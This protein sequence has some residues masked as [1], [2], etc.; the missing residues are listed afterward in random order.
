MKAFAMNCDPTFQTTADRRTY[1]ALTG[2]V[3]LAAAG[4]HSAILALFMAAASAHG[5]STAMVKPANPLP[6]PQ[7]SWFQAHPFEAV[8]S[9]SVYAWTAEDGKNTNVIL[10]LAHNEL[11]HQRMLTENDTIYRRQLVY[12]A[13]SFASQAQQ[14]MQTGRSLRHITLP[15]LDGQLL[16]VDVTKTDFRNG[17]Q[18]GEIYGKLAGRPD[19][20]VTVAFVNSREAFTVIS[21]QDQIYLQAEAR[22][23]GEMVVK[24]INPATY[25]RPQK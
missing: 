13:Q 20:M 14:A 7:F 16:T 6:P 19:S 12:F 21:P 3:R 15:S 22:E 23:P 18:K 4:W 9:N 8:E 11:E 2:G 25:G 17:G 1:R 10:H 24:S 5:Q